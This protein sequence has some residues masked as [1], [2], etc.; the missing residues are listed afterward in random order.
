MGSSKLA[1]CRILAVLLGVLLL[2]RR[3]TIGLL[4]VAGC[5]LAFVPAGGYFVWREAQ[6]VGEAMLFAVAFAPGILTGWACLLVFGRP[7]W[8]HLVSR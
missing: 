4:L 7:L 3:K 1:L 5:C 8:W 6:Y 2:A